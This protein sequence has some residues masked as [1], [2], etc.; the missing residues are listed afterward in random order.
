MGDACE[1]FQDSDNDGIFD[2]DDN[3]PNQ[4]NPGQSDNDDDGIGNRCDNCPNDANFDQADSDLDGTGDLCDEIDTP[5][6]IQ[7]NWENAQLDFDLHLINPRG[8][9]FSR[10]SDCWSTNQSPNW[11]LPGLSGDAPQNGETQE[12]ISINEPSAGWHTVAVD[13][14][15]GRNSVT[16]TAL[17]SLACNGASFAFGPQEIT[18]EN[19]TNRSMWQ[20]F[21]FDPSTCEIEEISSVNAVTCSGNRAT[22]CE[23][24]DCDQGPCSLC[25]EEASCDPTS[26]ECNDLCA[27]VTCDPGSLCNQT[28][29][30]CDSA[31]CLPCENESDCPDGSYCIVYTLQNVQACAVTCE[32]NSDCDVGQTCSQVIR[33]RQIVNVCADLENACQPDLCE[34]VN[35]EAGSYCDPSDGNCVT[36]VTNDQCAEGEACVDQECLNGAE[37][38]YSSWGNGNELPSC[39][40]C[41]SAETCQ[42]PRVPFTGQFCALECDENLACPQ[43]LTCCNVDNI[44][45]LN[46]SLCVDPRNSLADFVCGG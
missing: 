6:I 16:G 43:G 26:G 10:E 2:L 5:V 35:C 32:A 37:R 30:A 3:C 13:L 39:D 29:G 38:S 12:T 28:T 18:S 27:D 40:Q 33:D 36:C 1:A 15:T 11:A 4:V 24:T 31:Q 21:R 8:V 17:L 41:T 20:V 22:S 42:D 19:N 9:F 23:C 46:G 25:P 45:S 44:G 7:L 34:S 14:F